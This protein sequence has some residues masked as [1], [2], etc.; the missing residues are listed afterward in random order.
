MADPITPPPPQEG[1]GIEAGD[2]LP[3]RF[4]KYTLLRKLATGGMAE[5]FLALHRSVAG[6]EKLVVIKR[7]L[8]AMNQD[9]AFIEML[10]HEARVAATLSHPNIVQTFDVGM[11]DAT[12]YIAMEHIHGEDLRS[13]VRQMKK[14]G[15]ADFPL[16]HA[17]AV[18]IGQCSGLAYA[19]EKRDLEGRPLEIVHRDISPQN[20][21]V[22]FS[23]DV[24]IVDFGIA[25]SG[26]KV[27]EDTKSGQ[28]KGKVPYMSPEQAA[29][30]EIDWRSDI[31]ATGVM[32]FE[33][34][35]GR[36]LFKGPSEYETLKLICEK[37]Y[38]LPSQVRPGYSPRLE[39]IVMKALAKK[40]EE[41]YQT[42]REMQADLEAFVR[43]ERI[44]VSQIALSEWMGRLFKEKIAQQKEALQ[45]IKQLA[46]VIA[47]QQDDGERLTG[48]FGPQ[49]SIMP[50]APAA[51]RTI[52]TVGS[53]PPKRRGAWIGA[54]AVVAL[55][56]A[57]AFYFL[58]AKQPVEPTAATTAVAPTPAPE[59]KNRGVLS[60]A[61][62][63][64]GAAIWIDGDLRPETTPAKL[65]KL[66]VGAT[67]HVRITKDGFEAFKQEVAIGDAESKIDA[68]LRKGSVTL[69]VK[70]NVPSF[71]IWV[72]GK[73]VPGPT[74]DG[75]SAG[76]EHKV[77][78]GAAGY[79]AKTANF[80]AQQGETKTIEL[81][82][83]KA[84]PGDSSSTG[85][86][87]P[88]PTDKPAAPSGGSGKLNVAARGG[89][90][91]VSVDGAGHGPTPVGGIVLPAGTHRVSC[92]PDSGS[93]MSQVVKIEDGQ[94]ARIS[95]TIPQ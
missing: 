75:L 65:D 69:V 46:D 77:V 62:D 88:P 84:R 61:T 3:Q 66:P 59:N 92:K 93:P 56:G 67:L 82:L 95:F 30:E 52:T 58:H 22:T 29:G 57:G 47:A 13:I 26:A 15:V 68:K 91:N 80:S 18:V 36:R 90:C 28:L 27:G 86:S 49:S 39:R 71:A 85:G 53:A 81:T 87:A 6:F 9:K 5:L 40:R 60:I 79:A 11:I 94:T 32:L 2:A 35:T 1:R 51:S 76:D 21:V 44:P 24:K 45:D 64:P 4:G 16:P 74:V 8:P 72:D 7:I 37:D 54:V 73:S 78:V 10:L 20:V 89:Y 38:P 42:A 41:R 31:F 34:T 63:P 50:T 33:L 17:L 55:G 25:K 14:M 19:H 23:G 12:Y 43:D 48:E 83:E 70:A